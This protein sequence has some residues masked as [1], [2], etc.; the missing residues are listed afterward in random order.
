MDDE[1]TSPVAVSHGAN[2]LTGEWARVRAFVAQPTLPDR[3]SPFSGNAIAGLLR[4]YALD[5]A[6][7]GVLAAIAM[8]VIAF[9]VE[10]PESTL[11]NLPIT[12]IAVA[13]I[14]IVVPIGEEIVFRGWLGGRKRDLLASLIFITG[15][16]A[17]AGLGA[18]EVVGAGVWALAVLTFTFLSTAILFW[19]AR[20]RPAMGWFA[21]KF[22]IFFWLSTL[23]FACAH[24][25]NFEEGALYI[26]LPMVLPQFVGGVLFGYL[27][28]TYGLWASIALH[29]LHNGTA[30]G[31]VALATASSA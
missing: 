19:T 6:A 28:V 27:R 13:L 24:L 12:P 2:S 11:E 29:A 9:G 5:L 8:A 4:V 1:S 25:F 18:V 15:I 22:P 30:I 23:A 31:L 20:G 17:A 3:T 14:V 26:L 21:R 10:L 7:M 16:A